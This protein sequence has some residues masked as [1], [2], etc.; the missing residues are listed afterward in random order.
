MQVIV[1]HGDTGENE[2]PHD[3]DRRARLFGIHITLGLPPS[4]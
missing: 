4:P 3:Q 2:N 1:L